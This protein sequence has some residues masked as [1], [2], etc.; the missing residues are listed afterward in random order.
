MS[1]KVKCDSYDYSLTESARQ[2]LKKTNKIICRCSHC[3]QQGVKEI[4]HLPSCCF[5]VKKVTK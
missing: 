1:K 2:E 5:S 4:I 3:K